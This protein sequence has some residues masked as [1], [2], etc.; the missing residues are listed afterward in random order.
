MCHGTCGVSTAKPVHRV[1]TLSQFWRITSLTYFWA[2]FGRLS[3]PSDTHPPWVPLFFPSSIPLSCLPPLLVCHVWEDRKQ[4]VR[5]D[6]CKFVCVCT[7][8]SVTSISDPL[9]TS[10]PQD[11]LLKR[12]V[13][14]SPHAS[15]CQPSPTAGEPFK[16]LP[17]FLQALPPLPVLSLQPLPLPLPPSGPVSSPNMRGDR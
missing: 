5:A 15:H 8:L 2:K 4:S 13:F 16:R 7:R 10:A 17:A 12:P 3:V 6:V 14:Y 9:S 11:C 1:R